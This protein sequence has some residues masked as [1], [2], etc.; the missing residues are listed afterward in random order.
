MGGKKN[1]DKFYMFMNLSSLKKLMILK[2][3]KTLDSLKKELKHE[4]ERT[5]VLKRTQQELLQNYRKKRDEL[6]AHKVHL[7]A[8]KRDHKRKKMEIEASSCQK[9]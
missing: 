6:V 3:R 4:K 8:M 9:E 5:K 1:E 7:E 2:L